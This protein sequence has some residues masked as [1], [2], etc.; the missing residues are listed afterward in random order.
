MKIKR[1]TQHFVVFVKVLFRCDDFLDHIISHRQTR[2]TW[3]H[4]F[5]RVSESKWN[6][7][8]ATI[9]HQKLSKKCLLASLSTL[10]QNI[11]YNLEKLLNKPS[12]HRRS[13]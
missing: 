8:K 11:E 13:L 12:E 5:Q 9:N 2:N 4:W 10:V 1:I 6:R 7:A 3:K